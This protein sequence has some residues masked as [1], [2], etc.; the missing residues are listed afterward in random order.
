MLG[1]EIDLWDYITFVSLALA[2]VAFI[3][4]I[5][6]I[7]GLP[8]RIAVSRNHPDAQA[9]TVMGWAG[10]LAVVPWMQAFIWAFKPTDKVD[11]RRFPREEARATEEEIARLKGETPGVERTRAREEKLATLATGDSAAGAP[12]AKPGADAKKAGT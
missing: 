3:L 5:V 7:G 10:L 4:I 2:G 1:F 11:I 6:F 8:G 12:P 9:V